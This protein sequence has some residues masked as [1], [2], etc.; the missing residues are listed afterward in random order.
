MG[1]DREPRHRWYRKKNQC[2]ASPLPA[3]WRPQHTPFPTS[4]G[5][6]RTG[7]RPFSDHV[8]ENAGQRER[9]GTSKGLPPEETAARAMSRLARGAAFTDWSV[10][11]NAVEGGRPS[12]GW[13]GF[14]WRGGN[15]SAVLIGEF[16]GRA[17]IG[18]I[19]AR[20]NLIGQRNEFTCSG[21]VAERQAEPEGIASWSALRNVAGTT[22]WSCG[23]VGE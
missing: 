21:W 16:L 7:A 11:R 10:A 1:G 14:S 4:R 20:L 6:A 17:L 15:S 18:K 19:G 12:R 2:N 8:T 5:R 23:S 22:C 13:A 9:G 3:K